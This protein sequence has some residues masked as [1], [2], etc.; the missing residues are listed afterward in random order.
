MVALVIER[1][2]EKP[3]EIKDVIQR[4][5]TISYEHTILSLPVAKNTYFLINASSSF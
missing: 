2:D 4:E 1:Q 5:K 3:G